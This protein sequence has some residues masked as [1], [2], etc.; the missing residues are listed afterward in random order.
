MC[1]CIYLCHASWPNENDTDLKFGT[2]TPI[3]LILKS[4]TQLKYSTYFRTEEV[5]VCICVYKC[6]CIYVFVPRLLAKRKTIQT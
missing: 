1:V 2:H 6:I 3:D 5:Y 4:M